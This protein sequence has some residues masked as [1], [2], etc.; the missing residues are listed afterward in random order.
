MRNLDHRTDHES[1]DAEH[2][3]FK[4]YQSVLPGYRNSFTHESM[5]ELY[6]MLTKVAQLTSVVLS[7][8]SRSGKLLVKP[9]TLTATKFDQHATLTIIAR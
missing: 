8:S 4:L 2:E 5:P 6:L 7:L 3:S 9:H 1:S